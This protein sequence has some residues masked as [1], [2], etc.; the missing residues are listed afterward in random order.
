MNGDSADEYEELSNPDYFWNEVNHI[1]FWTDDANA[2][3]NKFL[4][5]INAI[6][7]KRLTLM[8]GEL[9][10]GD[11]DIIKILTNIKFNLNLELLWYIEY[12]MLKL[13]FNDT[14]ILIQSNQQKPI[15]IKCKKFSWNISI[16]EID[17]VWHIP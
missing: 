4:N 1:K 12:T 5:N 11:F 8:L 16:N 15:I 2:L 13:S 14:P 3:S 10:S 17:K 7:P 9:G 6:R